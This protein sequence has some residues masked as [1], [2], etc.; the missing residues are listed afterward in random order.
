MFLLVRMRFRI[1]VDTQPV[2]CFR[3]HKGYAIYMRIS[4]FE[5]CKCARM[6]LHCANA[7]AVPRICAVTHIEGTLVRPL[8]AN[9]ATKKKNEMLSSSIAPCFVSGCRHRVRNVCCHSYNV[10]HA[11]DGLRE[12]A[13]DGAK[14][15]VFCQLERGGSE[16]PSKLLS[17]AL[18]VSLSLRVTSRSYL[19]FWLEHDL[20][21]DNGSRIQEST[22]GTK[23]LQYVLLKYLS[24]TLVTD[25][26]QWPCLHAF[27]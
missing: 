23:C 6:R 5:C 8:S 22:K 27:E 24:I 4:N 16:G 10:R 19:F 14:F 11:K 3:R 7:L 21:N 26:K 1:Y 18:Q 13:S 2:K 15:V 25:V 9:D 20:T 17:R 12:R